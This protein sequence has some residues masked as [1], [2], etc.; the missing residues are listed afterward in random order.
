MSLA[1][2]LFLVQSTEQKIN[3]ENAQQNIVLRKV[4]AQRERKAKQ[5]TDK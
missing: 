5:K 3:K 2:F 4:F 1:F